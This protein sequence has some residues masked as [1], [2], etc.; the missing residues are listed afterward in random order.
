MFCSS[1]GT[2]VAGTGAAPATPGGPNPA[3]LAADKVKAASKDALQ[4]FKMFA[5]NPVGNLAAAFEGLGSRALAVGIAFGVVFAL[6]L[7]LGIYRFFGQ[8]TGGFFEAIKML[9]FGGFLKALV[10]G[11]VPFVT[12]GAGSFIVRQAFRG[13]GGLGYDSFIAGAS[14][15]PF[16]GVALVATIVGFGNYDIIGVFALFAVCLTVLML[17]AG[18]TRISRISERLA[19]LAIP[20]M[21]IVSAWLSKVIYLAMFKRGMMM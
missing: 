17:F 16:G 19:T 21:V 6:C 2:A 10:F 7:L 11:V 15:L 20:I 9:K 12:L 8:F 4:A 13:G 1:C 3:A 18:L 14:L 5:S